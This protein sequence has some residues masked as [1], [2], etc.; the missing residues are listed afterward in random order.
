[1]SDRVEELNQ[2]LY[3]RLQPSESPA[4][5]FSPRPVP[6]KYVKMPVVNDPPPP[7]R[8]I[9]SRAQTVAFLPTDA[10][11]PGVLDLTD[12]ESTLKN[13]DFALQKDSRAYYVPSSKSDLYKN[14]AP[15]PTA[16]QQPHPNLF[17]N[18]LSQNTGIPPNVTLPKSIFNNVRLRT[19][20]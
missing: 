8:P 12:I 6:T 3:S 17:T 10:R 19:P 11:G 20:A 7:S 2:R 1:M 9:E 16:V 14:L 5:L 15:K 4:I 13:M 18:V